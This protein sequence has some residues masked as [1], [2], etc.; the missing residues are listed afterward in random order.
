MG[1]G[2]AAEAGL[3][4]CLPPTLKSSQ[5]LGGYGTSSARLRSELQAKSASLLPWGELEPAALAEGTQ[6]W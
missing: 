4:S 5:P 6:R 1:R 2:Q 3:A